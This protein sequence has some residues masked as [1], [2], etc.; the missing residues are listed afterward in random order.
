M[1]ETSGAS[2]GA[3]AALPA[4]SARTRARTSPQGSCSCASPPP[5][6]HVPG[7][8]ATRIG[9]AARQRSRWPRWCPAHAKS[10]VRVLLATGWVL[11][12]KEYPR[13]ASQGNSRKKALARGLGTS[14]RRLHPT[15]Q[16]CAWGSIRWACAE[17]CPA[18]LG[19]H[20]G[21]Q[22]LET[23]GVR[24]SPHFSATTKRVLRA[25]GQVPLGSV[26]PTSGLACG[27]RYTGMAG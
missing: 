2:A 1:G 11:S 4:P 19:Y 3:R 12:G 9:T 6:P 10:D 17:V 20:T 14:R 13:G 7:W 5:P 21:K 18:D 15:I 26:S 25:Q 16:H 23:W 27:G 24:S 22:R 8:D